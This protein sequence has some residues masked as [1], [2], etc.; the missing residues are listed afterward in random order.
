[1][2][3]RSRLFFKTFAGFWLA[4]VAILGSWL[5]AARYFETTGLNNLPQQLQAAPERPPRFM[6]GLNYDLEN[7]E[8]GRL[9]A[10]V[11]ELERARGV[12]LWLLQRDGE[13]LLGRD[14]PPE[15]MA[16]AEELRGRRRRAMTRNQRD[17]LFAHD[18]YN[19]EIGHF[20]MVLA[21]PNQESRLMRT[22]GP[23]PGLRLA[24]AVLVSGLLCFVLSRVLTRR[25]SRLQLAAR[26]LAGGE[27]D[28]RIEVR[29]RG[30]DETDDLARDFN[31][32]A[33]E[34]QDRI[35]S[36]RRLLA[37]VSHE[38]RSP[39]A[40]LRVALALAQQQRPEGDAQLDRIERETGRLETLIGQL[41]DSRAEPGELDTHIDLVPLLAELCSDAEFEF[42]DRRTGVCFRSAVPTAPVLTS[43][44]L[45]HRAFGNI[46]RNAALHSPASAPVEVSLDRV[47]DTFVTRIADCGPGVP[48]AE[49]ERIFDA[50]YRVDSARTRESGGAG[51]GLSIARRA[52]E[53]HGGRIEAANLGPGLSVTVSL[54]VDPEG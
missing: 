23:R 25:I 49:L 54:P 30:G 7:I 34:L 51:L 18:I 39:L 10:F 42:A 46:L 52:V 11:E 32:M 31:H 9:P 53:Q 20:R 22:L 5:L 47:G 41:L 12:D 33:R 24:L 16:L 36:Q 50:F 15:A 45:L 1:V 40:R 2:S 21:V 43:G 44:D 28:T 29:S 26:R 13:E 38:L 37:D 14:A 4:T 48:E 6:L 27:L 35:Q 8:P 17:T 19:G 3:L